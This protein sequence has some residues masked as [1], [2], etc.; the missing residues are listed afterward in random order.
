[1][2]RLNYILVFDE[3]KQ[4]N[5]L[6][7]T[8]TT[9]ILSDLKKADNASDKDLKKMEDT[10]G[11]SS[12]DEFLEKFAP[13]VYPVIQ[14]NG[15]NWS[16][17]PIG[18]VKPVT[19]DKTFE[20]LRLLLEVYESRKK[21]G[22]STL[23]F[24]WGD[25]FQILNP[26]RQFEKAQ[27]LRNSIISDE[28]ELKKLE[29]NDKESPRYKELI[30]RIKETR[31]EIRNKYKDN[32]MQLLP[33]AVAVNE[34]KIENLN[35]VSGSSNKQIENK[36]NNAVGKLTF[37]DNGEIE[38]TETK[39]IGDGTEEN[40]KASND[41]NRVQKWLLADY[42]KV[43]NEPNSYEQEVLL[44]AFSDKDIS[45]G[46]DENVEE[47]KNN[48]INATKNQLE[49]YRNN[50]KSSFES[51]MDLLM[52]ILDIKVLFDQSENTIDLKLIISN[53][54]RTVTGASDN[55]KHLEKILEHLGE[56]SF[57]EKRNE[58]ASFWT[59]VVP[60][61]STGGI[62]EDDVDI[63]D[64]DAGLDDIESDVDGFS[65]ESDLYASKNI[66]SSLENHKIITFFN[67][68][69]DKKNTFEGLQKYGI[70][71]YKNKLKESGIAN[72]SVTNSPRPKRYS[73]PCYP[74][75]TLIGEEEFKLD[76][77]FAD[78]DNLTYIKPINIDAA[79]VAAGLVA[80][81]LNPKGLKKIKRFSLAPEDIDEKLPGAG[82]R[83]EQPS[84]AKKI[85]TTMPKETNI[86]LT[87]NL[88]KSII[89]EKELGGFIF[90]GDSKVRHMYPLICRNIVGE[91]LYRILIY[92]YIEK[93]VKEN[94]GTNKQEILK[95]Q[96]ALRIHN[97][98][99]AKAKFNSLLKEENQEIAIREDGKIY[100]NL[101][102]KDGE[103]QDV[104]GIVIEINGN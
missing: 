79:Y 42:S 97:K 74:N 23:E 3:F 82:I 61:I 96:D 5:G 25:I 48:L 1:M 45:I 12:F 77:R 16:S 54:K 26:K 14:S 57:K 66:I 20:P 13:V 32:P 63:D 70:D 52:K 71:F 53:E 40:K 43:R 84:I 41:Q 75:F 35:I 34:K 15:I 95:L 11:V 76:L 87:E 18:N 102:T 73:V 83:L 10:L 65:K 6:V 38:F 33:L 78:T 50:L 88:R 29:L 100:I 17:T 72:L 86:G 103:D 9:T 37:K 19:I 56:T 55:I 58:S 36:Q 30:S 60:G 101:N 62:I 21:S 46:K 99:T 92:L 89:T 51:V 91:K 98:D 81:Y 39:L 94:A 69:N 59:A 44:A 67:F 90:T 68:E 80:A 7:P 4:S 22:Q 24:N 8:L 85:V 27:Q 93:Y 28:K 104:D 31:I 47:V 49:L 64:I 2:E